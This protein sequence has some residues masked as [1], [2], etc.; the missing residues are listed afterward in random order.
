MR[1]AGGGGT[2]PDKVHKE[3]LAW[4]FPVLA[5][6]RT[7]ALAGEREPLGV[8]GEVAGIIGGRACE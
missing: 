8:K 5:R 7:C 1:G 3:L 4:V 6:R 2:S